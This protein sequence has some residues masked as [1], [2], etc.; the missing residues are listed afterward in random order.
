MLVVSGEQDHTVPH[1][2]ANAAYQ[3]QLK[4]SGV[5]EFAEIPGRGALADQLT[6]AG[7]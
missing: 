3:H 1:V 2:L 6:M 5:T 4:N 7:R